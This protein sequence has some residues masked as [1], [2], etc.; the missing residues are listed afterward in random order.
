MGLPGDRRLTVMPQLA[1]LDGE[2]TRKIQRDWV[3]LVTGGAR[4]VTAEIA[5]QLAQ[6]HQPTLILAGASSLPRA[7]RP[8]SGLPVRPPKV[9]VFLKAD[10]RVSLFRPWRFCEGWKA[11]RAGNTMDAV[12]KYHRYN[13]RQYCLDM[14][15][16]HGCLFEGRPIMSPR[17]RTA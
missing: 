17:N 3:F 4:G 12:F 14:A 10:L 15:L 1:P 8:L 5:R 16:L 13:D 9:A 7:P 6:R 2:A 11:S